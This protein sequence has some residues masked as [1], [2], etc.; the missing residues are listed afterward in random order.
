MNL[1]HGLIEIFMRHPVAANLLMALML[2]G[3]VIGLL[4]M[5]VQFLPNFQ[6][7]DITITIPWPGASADDVEKSIIYPLERELR[8]VDNI[9][10]IEAQARQN[11]AVVRIEF[12]DGADMSKA[13]EE[14]RD[15]IDRVPNFPANS[16]KPVINRIESDERIASILLYGPA[17]LDELRPIAWQAERELLNAGISRVEVIGLPQQEIS[18]EFTPA[19]LAQLKSSLPQIAQLIA[20]ESQDIPAGLLGRASAGQNLRA[21][22]KKR[23]I[24]A[25]EEMRIPVN[26]NG[27]TVLLRHIAKIRLDVAEEEPRLLYEGKPA[28]E[29]RL[30]RTN[31]DNALEMA[32]IAHAWLDKRQMEFGSGIKL[33]IFNESWIL[34]QERIDTLLYNGLSGLALIIL[35][36]FIFLNRSVAY[37]V[38]LGIPVSVMAAMFILYLYDGSINM[39][40]LFAMILTL[41]IIVDDTIVIGE[42]SLSNLNTNEQPDYAILDACSKMMPAI[43]SSSLTTI[44]AFLPLMLVGGIIGTILF[45]IPMVVI[46]V[47]LASII[48]G[49]LVLPGHLYHSALHTDILKQNAL[50][51][52]LDKA[53]IQFRQRQFKPL[54]RKSLINHQIV[55]VATLG[56]MIFVIALFMG[57]H[58]KFTFFPTPDSNIIK[59]NVQF[60]AGTPESRRLEFLQYL[61]QSG[62]ETA[63][64][65]AEAENIDNPVTITFSTL[66]RTDINDFANNEGEQYA[67][68]LIELISGDRRNFTNQIMMREWRAAITI[69]DYV[70]SLALTSP[71]GGPP[72]ADIDIQIN[73]SNVANIKTALIKISEALHQVPGVMGIEDTLPYAQEQIIFALNERGKAL[74]L[75]TEDIGRQIRA[76]LNGEIVQKFNNPDE[77]IEV[78][79]R[80]D[81]SIRENRGLL[82]RLLVKTPQNTLVPLT[83][84]ITLEYKKLPEIIIHNDYQLSANV[85]AEV[86]VEIANANETL[87]NLSTTLLPELAKKYE[88]SF[89]FE[90]KAREQR[91]TMR[92]IL[93]GMFTALVLIYIILAWVFS[94]YMLPLIVMAAIPLGLLGAMIG[95]WLM[96]LDLT[97]LSIFGLFGLSGIVI[98]D[99]I[100]LIN[101]YQLLRAKRMKVLYAIVEAS[102]LRLRAIFLTSITTI[103]GLTP[104]LFEQSLQAQF[105]IPMA[106][107]I[108]FGLAFATVLLLIVVPVLIMYMEYF[109]SGKKPQI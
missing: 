63:K 33:K 82:S 77:E 4:K 81:K 29:L 2:L 39:V 10:R 52:R 34:I 6:I 59:A 13:S 97:L 38:S 60:V 23:N 15:A 8:S 100:I 5:N 87:A 45:S 71:R 58:L 40:S 17:Q 70:D 95:H 69:P 7:N 67:T 53:I 108:T 28:V 41:G 56:S 103:V 43:L 16:E 18:I 80:L 75:K 84:V 74:G 55:S 72:G 94:S 79:V 101:E 47:I 42:Q 24:Q 36:L 35:V 78:R 49:F 31:K 89:Q 21:V 25:F 9:K 3:G 22:E 50:R 76:S 27:K 37:W 19:M 64:R 86:D 11:T 91:E 57:G 105:L 14:V 98:N 109:R 54:L 12:N 85:R 68:V 26:N 30:Y 65:L 96:G 1:R 107:S 51:Q 92:D 106:C 46:C 32:K 102:S 48:E 73:G 66:N 20:Q 99:S 83:E 90:G 93:I 61:Q 44:S 104:L 62:V 88:I